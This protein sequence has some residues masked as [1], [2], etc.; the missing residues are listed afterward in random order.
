MK[1]II[2][3][4][5]C[6][7]KKGG[8]AEYTHNLILSLQKQK[9]IT[10]VIAQ[11]HSASED[12]DSQQKYLIIRCNLD[13]QT[14]LLKRYLHIIKTAGNFISREKPDCIILNTYDRLSL[15]I[16]IVSLWKGLPF[17]ILVHGLD[18]AEKQSSWKE[19]KRYVV[20]RGTNGIIANSTNTR[21][22]AIKKGADP[23]KVHIVHPGVAS[24]EKMSLERYKKT[25]TVLC[26]VIQSSSPVILSVGRLVPRKGFDM[27][28]E[29]IPVVL[30]KYPNLKYVIIGDGYDRDRLEHMVAQMGLEENI[31]FPG[32]VD[33]QTKHA[34]YELA[35]LFIMPNRDLDNGDTEG[36]GIVFLEANLH[37]LPV[38]G[39]N[40]GGVPDAIEDG[41]SGLLV[42]SSSIQEIV[43]AI[44]TILS[45]PKTASRMGEYGRKRSEEQFNWTITAKKVSDIIRMK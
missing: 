11:N 5:D 4:I 21:K 38:I 34:Y 23:D 40:A 20:I 39:G 35:D 8:I 19:L 37:G 43:N 6:K 2:F 17:Y 13:P 41:K 22:I 44:I 9:I 42:N 25:G 24:Y 16:H 3:S 18:I 32:Q 27:V 36:F 1:I 12:F 7:P 33:E 15:A 31:L 14:R 10:I 28:I 45:N 30:K 29:S 26:S